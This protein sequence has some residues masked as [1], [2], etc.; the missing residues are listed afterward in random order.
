MLADGRAAAALASASLMRPHIL[1]TDTL[2]DCEGISC[3]PEAFPVPLLFPAPQ[4]KAE[5]EMPP[6][7]VPCGAGVEPTAAFHLPML[8][9]PI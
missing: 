2:R 3:E 6:V 8:T 1:G 5:R 4:R 7:R 9:S